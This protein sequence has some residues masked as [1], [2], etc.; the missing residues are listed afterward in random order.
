MLH[1]QNFL[2]SQVRSFD[3]Y[4]RITVRDD[5]VFAAVGNIKVIWA[6]EPAKENPVARVEILDNVLAVQS[7]ENEI[8]VPGVPTKQ[9][10]YSTTRV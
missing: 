8:I 10:N 9:L 7:G 1:V 5:R 6:A 4:F 3:G 2:G